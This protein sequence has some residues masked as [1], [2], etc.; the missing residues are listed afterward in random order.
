MANR[1]EIPMAK[2]KEWAHETPDIKSLPE[3]VK[4]SP[5]KKYSQMLKGRENINK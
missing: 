1:G 2:A 3:K 4:T 5:K